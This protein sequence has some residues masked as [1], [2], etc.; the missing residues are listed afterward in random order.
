MKS[1]TFIAL[2]SINTICYSQVSGNINYRTINDF[3]QNA[4]VVSPPRDGEIYINVKG[5]ANVK[6]DQFVAIFSVTQTGKTQTEANQII[7]ER[8]SE[9]LKQ[10][11]LQKN[12]EI[13]TDMISF[14]PVYD[15]ET[16]R[17]L[18]S[19]RTYNE[20]PKG[21]EIKKNIHIKF[22]NAQ[23]L[24][25][26]IKNLAENEIYDL[27]RV[28]YYSTKL[29]DIKK[30]VSAK[31]KTMLAEKVK[32]YETIAAQT[33]INEDKTFSDGF[34]TKLPVE[35]YKSYEAYNSSSLDL[36]RSSNIN[37]VSKNSTIYYQPIF[38]KDFDFVLNPVV[39][40]PVI[41]IMYEVKM[42]I[43]KVQTNKK[44]YLIMNSNG[45]LKSFNIPK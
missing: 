42:K 36:V 29:D 43:K 30:E 23:Q 21:F 34:I 9:S 10:I 4:V 44:E 39:L 5:M 16:V 19:K 45:D 7:D 18:F 41:Q 2:L 31:A 37:Q 25:G 32:S 20:I 1:L 22:S 40:E 14:V 33:F 38:D 15:Y 28:D 24:D 8:I 26:F 6:A 13:F 3:S 12:V 11:K 17:K 35:M 27:V